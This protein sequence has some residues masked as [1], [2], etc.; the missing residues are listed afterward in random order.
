MSR[1]LRKSALF[2][3]VTVLAACVAGGADRAEPFSAALGERVGTQ[4]SALNAAPSLGDFVLLAETAMVV[5]AEATV[6]GADVGVRS[7]GGPFFMDKA[8]L[9]VGSKATVSVGNTIHADTVLLKSKATVGD[10]QTN[11]LEA[12]K[13]A[14]HGAVAGFV[15][16]PA[17]PAVSAVAPGTKSI[18]VEK[19]KTLTLSPG[20]F[21]DVKVKE[22]AAL[23]LEA[24]VYHLGSLA[25]ESHARL[26]SLG[27]V[28]IRIAGKLDAGHG[29][30]LG[31]APGTGLSAKD[32]RIEVNAP[33]GADDDDD[34]D[35]DDGDDDDGG[36][37]K[38]PPAAKLG[39]KAELRALVVV[40]NG[41]LRLRTKTTAKGAFFARF[42]RVQPK[43]KVSFEDGFGPACP[44]SCDD[45]NA[46]TL[47]AC[48]K[49]V[50]THTAA[51]D[52]SACDDGSACT[53][54]DTCQA[55][56]CVGSS[57]V[58]CA[59][60][61]QC[62]DAGSCD[63]ATGACSNPAKADGTACN[64]GS[65]CTQT[66]TC[67][68]GACVGSSPVVC[69]AIN[70]CHDAGSCDPMTG[71]CSNPTK[72][73]GTSCS[74]GNACNGL[75]S[76]DATG[77]CQPGT[78]VAVDDGNP[79]TTDTCDPATGAVSHSPAPAGTP[80]PDADKCNGEE[81]CD[82][83]GKCVAGSPPVIDDGDASTLDTCEPAAGV[84]HRPVSKL[85]LTVATTLFEA[86]R[87][88]FEGADPIQEGVPLGTIDPLRI[89]VLRG[90]VITRDGQALP[91]VT[92]RIVKIDPNE[93]DYGS[94]LSQGSGAFDMAVNGGGHLTVLFEK[95][96][97]LP[98]LRNVDVPWRDYVA[99]PDVVLIAADATVTSVA[100]GAPAM[101][102][103]RGSLVTDADGSRRAT[104]LVP[105]L[106]QASL[107]LADGSTESAS[108][109]GLRLTEYTVGASG[110]AAMPLELPPSS[111]YTYA[112]ELDADEAVAAG[113]RR[114]DFSQPVVFYVE[115]F[116]G[117]AAGTPAPVGA[118]DRAGGCWLPE[119]DGR[120]IDIVGE[121]ALLADIDSDGDGLADDPLT[122]AALGVSL[123]ERQK[124][125]ELYDPGESLFRLRL[126]HLSSIDIN[127]PA[128]PGCEPADASCPDP[129]DD[130]D[131]DDE[132]DD[133]NCNDESSSRVEIQPQILHEE[134]PVVGTSYSLHYSSDRVPGRKDRYSR[135]IR[136]TGATVPSDLKQ[137]DLLV[138]VAGR[139][140]TQAFPCP[141][142]PNQ[143]FVFQW[144]GRDGY[145]RELQG[146]HPVTVKVS[147]R[148][149]GSYLA[150]APMEASFGAVGSG[151]TGVALRE[152]LVNDRI[153]TSLLGT[154]R[155][156][157]LG[158]GG[159]SLSVHH[160]YDPGAQVLYLGDGRR[161][162]GQAIGATIKTVA[163]GVA[164]CNLNDGGKA[165]SAWL[166]G[167][168]GL[169]LAPDGSIYFADQ[170]SDRIRRIK[171]GGTIV[172]VAGSGTPGIDS[173][174]F[175][176]DGGPATL[177]KLHAPF[178]VALAPDGSLYI[179]D[180]NN[181]R[182]RRVDPAGTIETFAGT[183]ADGASGD[184]GPATLAELR[185]PRSVAF[186]PDCALYVA[187]YAARNVRRID[188]TGIITTVAGGGGSSPPALARDVA[189]FGPTGLAFGPDGSL[190]LSDDTLQQVL[191]V[192][193]DGILRAV[194]GKAFVQGTSGDGGPATGATL[195]EPR[196]VTVGP[197][198]SVYV[199]LR[200]V[201]PTEPTL[202]GGVRRVGPDGIITTVVGGHD[203]SCP[204]GS[205]CGEGGPARAAQ[206]LLPSGV[207]MGAFAADGSLY[208][209]DATAGRIFR[210]RPP[211]PHLSLDDVLF[212][213]EDGSEVYIL[214]GVGRH[215]ETRH[216]LLN[217]KLFSFA[218]D[219]AGRLASVTN[220]D[221]LVTAIN[222]DGAGNP[223][224]LTAPFGQET[225]LTTNPAGLLD[226]VTNPANE[227]VS[228][229]YGAGGL[230]ASFKN[231]RGFTTSYEHDAVGRLTKSI[232][233]PEAG[234]SR[235]YT[236]SALPT[237]HSV[238]RT[239]AL[240][241]STTYDRTR[242]TTGARRFTTTLPT[243]LQAFL[244]RRLDGSR[245]IVHPSGVQHAASLAPD[246]RFG[247]LTPL[248]DSL[249]TTP[250]NLIHTATLRRTV[251]LSNESDPFSLLSQS[252]TIAIA[253]KDATDV[254]QGPT[255]L[256]TLTTPLGRAL[257]TN[258]DHLSHISSLGVSGLAPVQ[259]AYDP[260][261]RLIT[262]VTGDR[263][264]NWTYHP[265]GTLA[266]FTNALSQMTSFAY[267]QAGRIVKRAFPDLSDV[268]Y[269]WDGT[270]NLTSVTPPGRPP[271]LFEYTPFNA[272][273][274]STLPD[275]VAG[276]AAT[277]YFYNIDRQLAQVD[278][279]DGRKVTIGYDSSARPASIYL[280]DGSFMLL[281]YD[282]TTGKLTQ[283]AGPHGVDL[284]YSFDGDLLTATTWSGAVSASIG[285]QYNSSFRLTT[286]TLNA[287]SHAIYSYDDDGLLVKAGDLSLSRDVANGLLTG[288]SLGNI[289]D[290]LTHNA[291][292]ELASYE[293]TFGGAVILRTDYVRDSLGRITKL[294]ETVGGTTRSVEHAY[295][296]VGRILAL[297]IDGA[298]VRSYQYDVNGNR[299]AVMDASGAIS[300][301]Y[302]ARDRLV[303]H[304]TTVFT[305][306]EAG[307]TTSK[308][309]TATGATTT[310]KY[311]SL[312]NLTAVT[313]P[314]NS[315]IEYLIDGM[316]RRVAKRVNGVL[317][318]SWIYR[319]GTHP[320]AE[321]DDMGNVQTRFVWADGVGAEEDVIR[322]L[323][324]R[325]GIPLNGDIVQPAGRRTATAD[326]PAY[327]VTGAGVYRMITDH[328]GSVRLV[329][330]AATGE[331]LQRI[332]YDDWGRVTLDTAPS[333]QPLGFAG[334]LYEASTGL[335]RFGARDYD[336]E[337]GRWTTPDPH[338][339][340]GAKANL[341]VYNE[342]DPVNAVDSTG[343]DSSL[344]CGVCLGAS[345]AA[346]I[347][348]VAA[349]AKWSKGFGEGCVAS[350]VAAGVGLAG[351]CREYFCGPPPGPGPAPAP[352]TFPPIPGPPPR[353]PGAC[354]D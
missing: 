61:N 311:D 70:Q 211:T 291:L 95:T 319:D 78:P 265:D 72:P 321:L 156:D 215:K 292:G 108:S 101:Q 197:D 22:K 21:G 239:T 38:A 129:G 330:N 218:Y 15:P 326:V 99:L 267:D 241:R 8:E 11:E 260:Q 23:R 116:L 25:L 312:G 238:T 13:K 277:T 49:G 37:P 285:R 36:G 60:I 79:C 201:T 220:V 273:S 255:R 144:D 252:D 39:Q 304:G 346:A 59:A 57:P 56:A 80:C 290:S 41:T 104:L 136:L 179:A 338:P 103:A 158:L 198:G 184:G 270:G 199:P 244:E 334:G 126:E 236:R 73:A 187:D 91:G 228:M 52:G 351:L 106:T 213:S 66:D 26:E 55:G 206:L 170:A 313:L 44:P 278:L 93:P 92:V 42:V 316:G 354:G 347:G 353:A 178:D 208:L 237:G 130:D 62:H 146:K 336:P 100:M 325:L 122:L 337:V 119:Q 64:D 254:F 163:G 281:S 275:V 294:S 67:Q 94:T 51:P 45:G 251:S 322:N 35:D 151:S 48:V 350:C 84:K 289:T 142:T 264:S 293:A 46:C 185:A 247:L 171:P 345:L 98:V 6:S 90:R 192:G 256:R 210:I 318:R 74:D 222:R 153:A 193:N 86:T 261:G 309:D 30:F 332:D 157:L 190:Y 85:D 314:N 258:Y 148:F 195:D 226:S 276:P 24:G 284:A 159:W 32:V 286:E 155:Q 97:F 150:P 233:P 147:Y 114:V 202:D 166:G 87:F 75:E 246:P 141:C 280:G 257:V 28:E 40:P 328:L 219:T 34:D 248:F 134:V 230:L 63:P 160:F 120:V 300:A 207:S 162:S 283:V 110:P 125:A 12:S 214:S 173:F 232:D 107:V 77:V 221:G 68:A 298:T 320:V 225:L 96:G 209:T 235:T 19:K 342:N 227:T 175:A 310:Y 10:V 269:T 58:V 139:S 282:A 53:Q 335:V 348:C 306:N 124:L 47:D 262:N 111:G 234:G 340:P 349:C 268:T 2:A 204:T 272:I 307:Q 242:L 118:L 240:G 217:A 161:R 81:S 182:I 168:R 253:G 140:F 274:K 88:L 343:L 5:F 83:M 302:D 186:G 266:T 105:A 324:E 301:S 4:A 133:N 18:K 27:P 189:L 333:V 183:G 82:G 243:G 288:T 329:V 223:T 89:A 152:D 17:P 344:S 109:L 145:G 135:A 297:S 149:D 43:A 167:P 299:I 132:D 181:R 287:T 138:Q 54:T 263:T 180:L 76:C 3:L 212:A 71:V 315:L 131:D 352:G 123:E 176:G 137:V 128:P 121:T 323:F 169:E 271:R 279:A 216:A 31:P 115:N 14:T 303:Q 113:A 112:V 117:F 20:A 7:A 102:A 327:L 224:K 341:Y 250:A 245:I 331:V 296:Q 188:A 33:N 194:A 231:A 205:Y 305:Y 164:C 29:T 165:L 203:P 127:F 177:P 308:T 249:T 295:D 339:L 174:G 200:D 65:A 143:S 16:L 9:G 196:S 1:R 154:F 50:C 229:T 259:L 191:R 172:T 317:V 69:A